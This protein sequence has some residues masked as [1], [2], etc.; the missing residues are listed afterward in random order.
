[1][2]L[3]YVA[4]AS[5]V[6]RMG[7]AIDRLEAEH[8]RWQIRNEQLQG[9]IAQLKAMDRIEREARGRLQMGPSAK[10]L[11]L[12]LPPTTA[13]GREGEETTPTEELPWKPL[14]ESWAYHVRA[15]YPGIN[16]GPAP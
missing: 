1:M 9:E 7:Y 3:L 12:T 13:K 10:T 15:L 11:F 5:A 2:S 14:F 6:A 8:A 4:Q 16:A